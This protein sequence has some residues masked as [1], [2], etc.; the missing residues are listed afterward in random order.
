MCLLCDK[1]CNSF[2]SIVAH[3]ESAAHRLLYLVLVSLNRLILHI[4]S[5]IN[6]NFHFFRRNTFRELSRYFLKPILFWKI[7]PH[8]SMSIWKPSFSEL[9][10]FWVAWMCFLAIAANG[11]W[12]PSSIEQKL[13]MELILSMTAIL[14][15]LFF[16]YLFHAVLYYR[17]T[18]DLDYSDI[19]SPFGVEGKIDH[20]IDSSA[21]QM[22]NF[23]FVR[24]LKKIF[25]QI[26]LWRRNFVKSTQKR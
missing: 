16:T 1:R 15:W 13:N 3:L 19:K 21:P 17:E 20:E 18:G 24:D 8:N 2:D 9:N 23:N 11:M 25:I 6:D 14:T 26:F 7:G 12:N 22:G 5:Y 10:R 4:S